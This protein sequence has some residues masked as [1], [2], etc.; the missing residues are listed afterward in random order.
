MDQRQIWRHKK[1]GERYAAVFVDGILSEAAG[2]LHWREVEAI[3]NGELFDP[4]VEVA[5]DL[6][7]HQDDYELEAEY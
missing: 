3:R 5:A 2:P 7:A 1:S 4:D 6:L